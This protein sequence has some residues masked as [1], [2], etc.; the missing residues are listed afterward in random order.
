MKD[1]RETDVKL[2]ILN[3]A[4]SLFAKQG[5]DGTSVRQICEEAGVNVALVSYHFGGKDGVFTAL[6]DEW[7]P[8]N[9]Y[10]E[11]DNLKDRPIE[12]LKMILEGA[13]QYRFE[14][15][16][17]VSIA[18]QEISM[19][20][21]RGM[22]LQ[23]YFLPAWSILRRFLQEGRNQ[24]IFR[25]DSLDHTMVM[26]MSTIILPPKTVIFEP[27]LE[28]TPTLEKTLQ[29]T[30]RFVFGGLGALDRLKEEDR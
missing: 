10:K 30:L 28:E 13:L 20:T 25:F 4:K 26:V 5:F 3:A 12:G 19:E 29:S 1:Q 14:H 8:H 21:R 24:G 23:R 16:E 7:F 27:L 9:R 18:F 11:L 22:E 2:K 6:Y 15:P 17:L